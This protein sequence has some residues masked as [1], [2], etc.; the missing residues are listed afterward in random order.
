[1]LIFKD[2]F[3]RFYFFTIT[4]QFPFIKV[5]HGFQGKREFPSYV[6][7]HIT[8]ILDVN[9]TSVFTFR[10][11]IG[12]LCWTGPSWHPRS[13]RCSRLRPLRL[14]QSMVTLR[15]FLFLQ[16]GVFLFLRVEWWKKLCTNDV[17]FFFFLGFCRTSFRAEF[18]PI[19]IVMGMV[20][21]ALTMGTHTAKQQ[22]MH[23]P[24]VQVS[25][26]RREMIPEVEDPDHSINAADKFL[27]KSFLRKIAH[28]QEDKRTLPDPVRANPYTRYPPYN[29]CIAT[30]MN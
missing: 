14:P 21:G 3:I 18:A 30:L 23:S 27:N 20:V 6:V 11:I 25:K 16:L 19:Y 29:H 17:H 28:I 9:V 5:G 26:K 24:S 12:D 13:R 2:H 10:V 1:M 4:S 7:Y 22:L 8:C 15:G